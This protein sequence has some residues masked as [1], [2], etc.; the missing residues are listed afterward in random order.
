M[1]KKY[2]EEEW[3]EDDRAPA[4]KFLTILAYRPATKS[5]DP[6]TMKDVEALKQLRECG[7]LVPQLDDLPEWR[8]SMSKIRK[9][10]K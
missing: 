9:E 5:W 1:T 7:K 2:E 3:P 8:R 10:I 4:E 6:E